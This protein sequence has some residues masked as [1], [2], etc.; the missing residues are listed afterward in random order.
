MLSMGVGSK[1]FLDLQSSANPI[2]ERSVPVINTQ[3]LTS[4][5]RSS[6]AVGHSDNLHKRPHSVVSTSSNSSNGSLV[7]S[8]NLASQ[9]PSSYVDFQAILE[10]AESGITIMLML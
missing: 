3:I 4:R 2:T 8:L 6:I 5:M 10:D 7:P 9:P 1:P